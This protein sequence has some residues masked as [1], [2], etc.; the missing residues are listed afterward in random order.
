[1]NKKIEFYNLFGAACAQKIVEII[2]DKLAELLF[3]EIV[4]FL[5]SLLLQLVC[6][7]F[8]K[9]SNGIAIR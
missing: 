6:A 9:L 4:F 3:D 1:M 8:R 5:L 2:Y 7:R